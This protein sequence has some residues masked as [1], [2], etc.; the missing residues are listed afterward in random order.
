MSV[1]D[2]CGDHRGDIMLLKVV[3]FS[4]HLLYQTITKLRSDINTCTITIFG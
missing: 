3:S 1:K 2:K 4:V